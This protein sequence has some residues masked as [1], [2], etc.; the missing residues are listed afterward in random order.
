MKA[1]ELMTRDPTTVTPNTRVRQAAQMMKSEDV[2]VLPVVDTEGSRKLVG[3]VTDRDIAIRCVA[4]G[5]DLSTCTVSECMSGDLTTAHADDDV[6]DVMKS[7]GKEQVRRIP[8][9][10]EHG[11]LVGIIAQADIALDADDKKAE[12]TV[13]RISRP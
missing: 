5:H 7:M 10:D 9:V 2:G 6:D 12:K 11:S 3:V 4:D 13:E 8:I 1:E